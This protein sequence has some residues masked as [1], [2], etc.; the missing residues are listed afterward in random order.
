[1]LQDYFPLTIFPEGALSASV[2]VTVWVGITVVALSNLR[3]GWVL[4]G[5]VVPGYV[6]PLLIVKPSAALV[7]FVEGVVTYWLVWL[8]SEYVTRF[9]GMSSFFG[10]D[11]FFA[12]V[13]TSVAV[14]IVADG[15]LLPEAGEW[16]LAHYDFAFDYQSNL[17]SFGLI[18]VALIAN[19][20]WKTGL[21]RGAWPM[22][23]QVG[24]TWLIVRWGL[25]ELTNFNMDSLAFMYEDAA[26]SFLAAPKAYIILLVTAFVASRFNL[27]YGWD[28]SGILIPSLLA[29]QWFEPHKILTTL[30]ETA[31]ILLLAEFALRLPVFRNTTMEGAR[32]LLLFFNL[33]FAYKFVL[34]WALVLLRPE[35]KVTDWFGFGY[36]LA[37]LLALKMH[38]KGIV[39]RVTAATLQTSLAGV[40]VATLLGFV[41]VLTPD[42]A[43][44]DPSGTSA[45]ALPA[46]ERDP[47]DI[48]TVLLA[49]KTGFY[50]ASLRGNAAA[51]Q[52]RELDAFATGVRR[53]AEYCRSKDSATLV[54]ARRALLGARYEVIDVAG[55]HLLLRPQAGVRHWGAYVLRLNGGSHLLV[56]APS[57]VDEAGTLEAAVQLFQRLE[58]RAFASAGS[59][60][61]IRDDGL[62]DVLTWPQTLFQTF[63]RELA[64]REVLQVRS[65]AQ[66]SV[67][68]VSGELP[69][70][71][72]LKALERAG[73]ALKIEFSP[74]PERNLQRQTLTGAF[75]E[76][77]M[78]PLDAARVARAGGAASPLVQK[79]LLEGI[80]AFLR[81]S[82]TTTSVAPS[83]SERF[84]TRPREELL[85]IDREVVSPLFG[86][87][88]RTGDP[89]T[90]MYLALA[91]ATASAQALGLEVRRLTTAAGDY[92]MVADPGRAHGWVVLRVGSA[93]NFLVEVPRPIVEAGVLE[94]ALSAF[95][96]FNARM[97]VIA[98]A[99]PDA[100][101]DGSADVLAMDN[102]G[103]MFTLA[104]QVALREMG[105][106][107]GIAMMVR[108]FG[109][110]PDQPAPRE[111]A[112]LSFDSTGAQGAALPAMS[113]QLIN[114]LEQSG[115]SVRLGGGDFDTA[116]LEATGGPQAGYM[117]QT[118]DKRFA[119]LWVSP[120]TRRQADAEAVT[121]AQRQFTALGL[122][123]RQADAVATLGARRF[124]ADGLSPELRAQAQRYHVTEDVVLLS[125]MRSR[126]P[127]IRLERLDDTGGRGAFLLISDSQGSLLGVMSLAARANAGDVPVRPG[128][129]DRAD[130]QRF[131][132]TRARWMVAR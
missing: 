123:V 105:H 131:V 19:N 115:L 114:T 120:L 34:A 25:M 60:R 92:L 36:L 2:I 77:W 130:A 121:L 101:R 126:K 125:A 94:I 61:R 15:W 117:S 84:K 10:R 73:V 44:K 50:A 72:D 43:W 78:N 23:V 93:Q 59:A 7:V 45:V 57:P 21:V 24:L 80:S 37:T 33:S 52:Q 86:L 97:I 11:R 63:H 83:A 119:V 56:G 3:L 71:L 132:S 70:A 14:R 17:H 102:A 8:Y 29:L 32:K 98:G 128:P 67:L 12:L 35:T 111:D 49:E 113:T 58:G 88:V 96:D 5:L 118:R 4:S 65:H 75:S 66:H 106:Q 54:D 108:A 82:I 64:P 127:A 1:M 112:V 53:L 62:L 51:P 47:R 68:H 79:T 18:I 41:L 104:H 103:S 13:L 85:R 99:A 31:V 40:V 42:S 89:D 27:F 107:P 124:A 22:A 6:V 95:I 74:P 110:R 55:N 91:S 122:E 87:A 38:D 81:E 109:L 28:F 9:T 16:M 100:N 129:V 26:T 76:L 116:G 90:D 20:F 48:A 46:I 69:D 30:V 39:A